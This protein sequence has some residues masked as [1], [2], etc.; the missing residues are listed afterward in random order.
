MDGLGPSC[1]LSDIAYR[2]RRRRSLPG[3][4]PERIMHE[5]ATLQLLLGTAVTIAAVHTALGVD[6]TL[7]FIAL[8]RA[9][10]WSMRKAL[11]VTALCGVGH[12]LSSVV[13]GVLGIALG[14]AVTRLQWL[15]NKRGAW[16]AWMLVAFG[17]FFVVRSIFRA[18]RQRQHVHD[19]VHHNGVAHVHAH[20]HAAP[21]HAHLHARAGRNAVTVWTLF[22]VFA[23]G[24]CE[25]LIPLLMAPAALHRWLWVAIVA[26]VF[27]AVTIAVM[28]LLVGLGYLGLSQLRFRSLER[29]AELLAGLAIASSGVLIQALGI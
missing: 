26:G 8:G 10:N 1:T 19:H 6:H 4:Y 20:H 3:A 18:L 28:V 17:S 2:T 12:V 7:P 23:F 22:I 24:P 15:E 27:G 13:L 25:P 11:V 29:H 9:K 14:A 5:T 16:A 21:E